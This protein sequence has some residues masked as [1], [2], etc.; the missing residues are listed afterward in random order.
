MQLIKIGSSKIGILKVG[1]FGKQ[2]RNLKSTLHI[3]LY[4]VWQK[5][6][7]TKLFTIICLCKIKAKNIYFKKMQLIIYSY[8]IIYI[9]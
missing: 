8:I 2:A 4:I 9:L 6:D 1:C 5:K 3:V 7:I